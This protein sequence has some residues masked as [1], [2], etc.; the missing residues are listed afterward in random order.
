MKIKKSFHKGQ[1]L[2]ELVLA[3]GVSAIIIVVLVS[4]VNNAVQAAAFSKNQTLAA[5]YAESATEWL[6]AQRDTNISTFLTNT[7]TA[8]VSWCLKDTPLIDTSWNEHTACATNDV[9]SGTIFTRQ[10]D[11]TVSTIPI[12]TPPAAAVKNQTIVLATVS[13][14]W[15]DAKG[16]HK[17]TNA[18]QFS[19]WRQR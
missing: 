17:I 18:T 6:R 9:V 4:L 10:V 15:S 12:P 3:I 2:F 16:T 14:S 11:F 13:V 7:S 8:P 1:S 19:D 5:R